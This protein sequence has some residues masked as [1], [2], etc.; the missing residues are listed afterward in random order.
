MEIAIIIVFRIGILANKSSRLG[1]RFFSRGSLRNN[2]NNRHKK[3]RI[4][5]S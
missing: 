2:C 5:T 1:S 3:S 4:G